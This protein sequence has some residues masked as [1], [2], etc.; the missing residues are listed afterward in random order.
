MKKLKNIVSTAILS[1]IFLGSS[2]VPFYSEVAEASVAGAHV[3]SYMDL[4]NNSETSSENRWLKDCL[5]VDFAF[6][7]EQAFEASLIF[8]NEKYAIIEIPE[9]MAVDKLVQPNGNAKVDAAV[10]V[11][12]DKSDLVN[13]VINASD[14]LV[15]EVDQVVN[16]LLKKSFAARVNMEEVHKELDLLRNLSKFGQLGEAEVPVMLSADGKK[17][18]VNIEDGLGI[19][20]ANSLNR[21]LDGLE[22]AVKALEIEYLDGHAYISMGSLNPEDVP[23]NI[24]WAQTQLDLAKEPMLRV[25]KDLREANTA[26]GS[27]LNQVG[28]VQALGDFKVTIPAKM[29]NPVSAS[30]NNANSTD[31]YDAVFKGWVKHNN[32][33]DVG[34]ILGKDKVESTIYFGA[35][36]RIDLPHIQY[37]EGYEDGNFRPEN[38]ITRA[39]A[40]TIFARILTSKT[41][42]DYEYNDQFT[43]V[44]KD[45]WYASGVAYLADNEIIKGYTDGT[46]RPNQEITRAELASIAKSLAASKGSDAVE[47]LN[48]VDTEGHWA[49]ELIKELAE[50][51]IVKGYEDETF[52]P[53]YD[54]TREE[55]A[56]LVNRLFSRIPDKEYIDEHIEELNTYEDVEA[57]RWSYYDI[58]EASNTHDHEYYVDDDCNLNEKWVEKK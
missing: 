42:L 9:D 8:D 21:I 43:D 23:Y 16:F 46:F 38:S 36:E 35:P 19:A 29:K 17:L 1:A 31:Q 45:A 51:G 57:E 27:A 20:V 11:R 33:L 12:F 39:E 25:I 34:V 4:Q 54:I 40:A 2:V 48:F 55:V 50:K 26:W 3:I 58:I 7:S 28:T 14:S 6:K 18:Y 32:Y 47:S 10:T 5:E 15:Y 52:K 30:I 53:D 49:K 24:R 44:D 56:T 13:K 37:F 22:N 41:K